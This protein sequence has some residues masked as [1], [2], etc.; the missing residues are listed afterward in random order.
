MFAVAANLLSGG[1]WRPCVFSRHGPARAGSDRREAGRRAKCANSGGSMIASQFITVH[2]IDLEVLRGGDGDPI[3]LLHGMRT[4]S[5]GSRFPALLA[6][7]GTVIA[8]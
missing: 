4:L 3:V 7:H 1:P 6:A 5:A 2:G 8:I